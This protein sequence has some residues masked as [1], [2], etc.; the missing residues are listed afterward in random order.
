L[1]PVGGI[2]IADY[3]FVKKRK[4]DIIEKTEFKNINWVAIVAFLVGF[5]VANVVT[6]G[7]IALNAIIT[8]V[9]VYVIGT[10]ITNK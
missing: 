8:T 9:L 7:V 2:I 5:I 3:F 10:K 4:Y 1:P 6:V